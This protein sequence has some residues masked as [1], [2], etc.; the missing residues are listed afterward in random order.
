M[1]PSFVEKASVSSK[2]IGG[3]GTHIISYKL[4]S[5]TFV[6]K[7]QKNLKQCRRG[8]SE[9][10]RT[11]MCVTLDCGLLLIFTHSSDASCT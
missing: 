6:K 9:D 3:G 4:S 5:A 11:E 10:K 8:G 2:V 1:I 7:L